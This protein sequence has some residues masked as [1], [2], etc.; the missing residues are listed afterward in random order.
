MLGTL[1]NAFSRSGLSLHSN[2]SNP[3]LTR[4][5]EP[6]VSISSSSHPPVPTFTTSIRQIHTAQ[7][8][9]YW[10]GRFRTLVSQLQQQVLE[11][12][13]INPKIL[14]KY[15]PKAWDERRARFI[16][17]VNRISK[18]TGRPEPE[19]DLY[20][21]KQ[22]WER[23]SQ[24]AVE[25]LMEE[26]EEEQI[27]KVLRTLETLCVTTEAKRSFWSWQLTYARAHQN[28][29]YLPVGGRM[30]AR[31]GV[32]DVPDV[33][34]VPEMPKMPESPET[35]E[36]FENGAWSSRVGRIFSRTDN[37]STSSLPQ[38]SEQGA[39]V[40]KK[41]RSLPNLFGLRERAGN[42]K[43]QRIDQPLE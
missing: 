43:Y 36:M 15:I 22:E 34:D 31:P 24:D 17:Y 39:I 3:N 27:V 18:V 14:A 23:K 26:E 40:I 33:P 2:R 28:E 16:N 41:K 32:P 9:A 1:S 10:S 20:R 19:V 37:G 21:Q 35:P 6:T 7:E 38:Q 25:D 4:T 5:G 30:V 29:K 8:N 42:Q 11:A 12:T 13:I